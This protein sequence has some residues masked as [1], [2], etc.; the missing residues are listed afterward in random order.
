MREPLR[1]PA[2]R[3][4]GPQPG[5]PGPASPARAELRAALAPRVP[6]DVL[7]VARRR[8]RR[9]RPGPCASG[10]RPSTS[11]VVI[12]SLGGIGTAAGLGGCARAG[13][14]EPGRRGGAGAVRERARAGPVADRPGRRPGLGAAQ[15]DAR[16]TRPSWPSPRSS[17][18]CRTGPGSGASATWSARPRPCSRRWPGSTTRAPGTMREND[19]ARGEGG[20]RL[21]ERAGRRARPGSC[22]SSSPTCG[23]RRWSR[24][25]APWPT[26]PRGQALVER[27]LDALPRQHLAA[28]TRRRHRP[29]LPRRPRPRPPEL[30]S[31]RPVPSAACRDRVAVCEGAVVEPAHIKW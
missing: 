5:R 24:A 12:A 21:D 29:R 30:M 22:A 16:R 28:Q 25:W 10:C 3:P 14:H 18:C 17:T 15:G 2:P 1:G 13:W 26:R 9:R 8:R 19:G 27:Q 20:H 31:D 23:P 11:D 6:V 7:A 4:G